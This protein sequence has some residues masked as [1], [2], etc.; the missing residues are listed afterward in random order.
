MTLRTVFLTILVT[1]CNLQVGS[2]QGV[3]K[4]SGTGS[5][6]IWAI[7]GEQFRARN[8]VL[9][10]DGDWSEA[11]TFASADLTAIRA[12]SPNDVWVA[13]HGALYHYDGSNWSTV[14]V[15]PTIIAFGDGWAVGDHG[16]VLARQGATWNPLADSTSITVAAA[17][18]ASADNLWAA[19]DGSVRHFDGHAWELPPAEMPQNL[20]LGAMWGS[21]PDDI[22][23]AGSGTT[24]HFDGQHWTSTTSNNGQWV[25]AIFGFGRAEVWASG[26]NDLI[27]RNWSAMAH[28]GDGPGVELDDIW[29]TS[30][31]DVWVAGNQELDIGGKPILRHF[32]GTSWISVSVP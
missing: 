17:W 23:A 5:R 28:G 27:L 21:G 4:L 2:D 11:Q 30:P 1:G 6:D 14:S 24:A 3:F 29:G 32:D 20:A 18:G 8:R 9:H 15:S 25:F 12:Y 19:V 13:G 7:A 10:Y 16:A 22:W 26:S 31:S